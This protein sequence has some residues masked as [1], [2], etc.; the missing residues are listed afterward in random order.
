MSDLEQAAQPV[1]TPLILGQSIELDVMAQLVL[2]QWTTMKMLVAE[3]NAGEVVTQF[4]TRVKFKATLKI[5][6][7]FRIWIAQCGVG[8][9]ETG[10][11]RHTSTLTLPMG[12]PPSHA[13]V[14]SVTFGIG[15]LLVHLLSAPPDLPLYS[16]NV[17]NGL[18]AQLIPY[19]GPISWPLPH[20]LT[21]DSANKIA[22]MLDRIIERPNILWKPRPSP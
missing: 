3:H 19:V 18:A 6:E 4:E 16:L 22:Y 5:P 13:N 17:D 15:Q 20:R 9:F 14:Q 21:F 7:D 12:E 1:L 8:G 10:F 11:Y 2:A